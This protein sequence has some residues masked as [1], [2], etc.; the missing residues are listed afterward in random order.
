MCNERM[1]A[2]AGSA[3]HLRFRRFTAFEAAVAAAP[4]AICEGHEVHISVP[5][6]PSGNQ[7]A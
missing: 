3:L 6:R 4:L 7:T 2:E 1:R 5:D